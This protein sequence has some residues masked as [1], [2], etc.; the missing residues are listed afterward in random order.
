M[1]NAIVH[2]ILSCWL[3]WVFYVCVMRL[4][5]LRDSG[6]LTAGQ[7]VFGYPTLFVGLIL[8]VVLNLILCTIIF[9]ELPREFTVSSR[10]WR[11]SNAEKS[12]RQ[13]VALFIRT[14]LLDTADPRGY[15]KG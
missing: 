4:Q 15:H 1:I 5:M 12:W 13:K 3:C 6:T 2:T 7:K 8:D 14:Q 10:L 11:H 9:V